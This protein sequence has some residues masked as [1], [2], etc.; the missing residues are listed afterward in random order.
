MRRLTR[1][2][3]QLFYHAHFAIKGGAATA[4]LLGVAIGKDC[5]IY[6][7]N[8]G[9]EPFLITIGDRTTITSGVRILTHDGSTGL[10]RNEAGHRYQRYAP[11]RIGDDVFIGVNAILMPGVTVHSRSIIGAGSVV[12]RDVAEGTI[13][14]GNPARVVGTFESFQAR[15]RSTCPND[16]DLKAAET[17]QARI[18]LALEI[19]KTKEQ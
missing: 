3:A 8:F 5:R 13:V 14:A 4:R 11:V 9:S 19:A 2:L 1:L 10:V 18:A 7:R 12:T 6:I 16:E 15:I 17:Y